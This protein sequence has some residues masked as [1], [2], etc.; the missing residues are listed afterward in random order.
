MNFSLINTPLQ[1]HIGLHMHVHLIRNQVCVRSGPIPSMTPQK[2]NQK[3]INLNSACCCHRQKNWK[4]HWNC[5]V[6]KPPRHCKHNSLYTLLYYWT[7]Q[8]RLHGN[9]LYFNLLHLFHLSGSSEKYFDPEYDRCFVIFVI[10]NVEMRPPTFAESR[11][12]SMRFQLDGASLDWSMT[13]W[14]IFCSVMYSRFST[15][16][17][18]TWIQIK[19]FMD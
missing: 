16:Y 1:M 17:K 5:L 8:S 15:K 9:S 12:E 19:A 4:R 14:T 13:K 10:R 7:R 11:P 2:M 18:P 6:S 3:K